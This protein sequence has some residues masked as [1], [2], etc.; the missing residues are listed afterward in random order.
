M[1]QSSLL[2]KY[3]KQITGTSFLCLKHAANTL[4]MAVCYMYAHTHTSLHPDLSEW[5]WIPL[6]SIGNNYFHINTQESRGEHSLSSS[7]VG[8]GSDKYSEGCGLRLHLGSTFIFTFF[9]SH[10]KKIGVLQTE[11]RINSF[12]FAFLGLLDW[13]PSFVCSLNEPFKPIQTIAIQICS[14]YMYIY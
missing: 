5:R 9:L 12:H 11:K 13:W 14:L 8:M 6:S 7:A 4:P 10:L 3:F 1:N 2:N